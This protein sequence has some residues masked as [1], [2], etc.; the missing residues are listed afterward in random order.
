MEPD[1][2]VAGFSL[3]AFAVGF[4]FGSMLGKLSGY[5][6][7]RLKRDKRGRFIKKG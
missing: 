3:L 1:L 5:H 4:T 6:D 2:A 7:A